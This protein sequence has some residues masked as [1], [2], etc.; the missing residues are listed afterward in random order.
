MACN[1]PVVT[2]RYD[3]LV[4]FI[5][6]T[7]GFRFFNGTPGEAMRCLEEVRSEPCAT[8]EAVR[9]Y[10]M[11]AFAMRLEEIYGRV[12]GSDGPS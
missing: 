6:P 2:T 11:D 8:R 3:A 10:G 4:R 1:I 12:L 7:Q 5:A 9:E